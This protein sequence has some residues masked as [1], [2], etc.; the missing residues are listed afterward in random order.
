MMR[1]TLGIDVG[2]SGAK[3]A[4]LDLDT[5]ELHGVAMRSYDNGCLQSSAMLWEATSDVI[6][7]AVA[8]V[9]PRAIG[10]ISLSGQMHG[11]VMFDAMG[12]TIE[13]VINWQDRRCD[14]PLACY[15]GRTTI[16]AMT[17]L[18]AGPEFDDLGV[19]TLASGFLGATLFYIKQNDPALFERIEHVAL[20]GDFIRGKLL[21]ESDRMT[22]PT[23]AFGAGIF[24]AR[25]G[26]WHEN[27]IRKL[28]LPRELL[29]QVR[30]SA[31]V[32]G[33]IPPRVA[34]T[35]N[36]APGIPVVVGGGDN[37]MS[38]FG[39]GLVSGSSPALVN[40]G[41]S[42]QLSQVTERYAR[43]RG[44]D[45]RSYFGGA[46]A[47]VGAT[48]GGGGSHA[49]L[50]R[51][52][53]QRAGRDVTYGEMDELAGRVAVGADGL[54]F[55][56][57]V[58]DLPARPE[59]FAGRLDFEDAGH[60]TRA[61]MEGVMLELH[62]LQPPTLD[63]GPGFMIG[64]GKG[65]QYSS[66]WGQIAADVFDRP[67]RITNF[68]NAVWGA[69]LLAALGTGAIRDAAEAFSTIKYTGEFLPCAANT[70]RYREV[71]AERKGN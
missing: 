9:D 46:F 71:I 44:I 7:G 43:K 60:R 55:L 32:A 10:G 1:Y 13:P 40:V 48:L 24:N 68:E 25:L 41:T 18:A 31:A 62:R 4:L 37:L 12:E 15:G 59:G 27:I 66:L 47:Y 52:L 36:L 22:D 57:A 69:A 58:R 14:L 45:T 30:D 67:V 29:P 61:L 54:A 5:F 49:G 56:P 42:G 23:N 70:K 39:T 6:R 28:G 16:Q 35:L 64:A 3:A 2:T 26:C 65:L 51:L 34:E 17:D 38:M 33:V 21:G 8:G 53:S 50:R 20:P 19:D 63:D 11:T